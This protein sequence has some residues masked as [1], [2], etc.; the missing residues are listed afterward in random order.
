MTTPVTLCAYCVFTGATNPKP[1]ECAMILPRPA[2]KGDVVIVPL[3]ATHAIIRCFQAGKR[4]K[5]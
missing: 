4:P 3:C 2:H 5:A 1:K